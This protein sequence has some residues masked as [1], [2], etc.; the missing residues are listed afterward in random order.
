VSDHPVKYDESIRSYGL[1]DCW[2]QAAVYYAVAEGLAGIEDTGRAFDS[3]RVSPRWASSQA[4]S[5]DIT[6]HYPAS[7]GYCSYRYKLDRGK[8]RITLDLSGSFG[9]ADIH[10]LLPGAAGAKTV[11][12]EGREV[13]FA[14]SRVE[15][16][17][18]V[19]FGIDGVPTRPVV[20]SY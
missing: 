10:C 17:S 13:S 9:K 19:D 1:P 14:N 6:L 15:K 5:A 11:T 2:A 12:V 3:V 4:S 18:Y 7:D 20:I 8:R 16:S